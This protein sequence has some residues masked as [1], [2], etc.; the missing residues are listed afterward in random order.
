MTPE[1]WKDIEGYEGTYQ[2]SSSGRVKSLNYH[3]TGKEHLIKQVDNG[4][5]YQ[6]VHLVGKKGLKWHTVH[7]LVA[8]A[9]ID[10]PHNKPTVNHI[11]GDRSN[12]SVENLEWATYSENSYHSYRVNKRK[13]SRSLPMVCIETG[14]KYNNAYDAARKTGYSQS[15]INRCVNGKTKTAGGL[16]WL[17]INNRKE[18]FYVN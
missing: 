2:V 12:N 13:P 11:N 18:N 8:S 10:N 3:R 1:V 9:F 14:K 15:S 5:G 17:L 7:R 6:Q 4:R 16:H